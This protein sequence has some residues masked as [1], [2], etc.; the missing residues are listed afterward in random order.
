V[1]PVTEPRTEYV[2]IVVSL[3]TSHQISRV[4]AH[5]ATIT[6]LPVTSHAHD[7]GRRRAGSR[8]DCRGTGTN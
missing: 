3:D 8:S 6:A 5:P 7:V 2:E 4:S 1:T